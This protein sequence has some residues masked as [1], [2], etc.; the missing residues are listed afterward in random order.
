MSQDQPPDERK[1]W[2]TLSR[3]WEIGFIIPSAIFVGFILGKL[4]DHWLHTRWITIAGV[5]LG[6]VA[7]FVEMIRMAIAATREKQ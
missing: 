7:G 5:C 2:A 6:I 3:Y 1:S 4:L